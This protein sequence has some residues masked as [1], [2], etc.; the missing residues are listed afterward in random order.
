MSLVR[1][2]TATPQEMETVEGCLHVG[3]S[4]C[5]TGGPTEAVGIQS[6]RDLRQRTW[7]HQ[8]MP[9]AFICSSS[10]PSLAPFAFTF[11]CCKGEVTQA[12][13][14]PCLLTP[15]LAREFFP[16]QFTWEETSPPQESLKCLFQM[17]SNAF[18]LCPVLTVPPLRSRQ[19]TI[20]N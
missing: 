6:L 19:S 11:P 12:S 8:E 4:T 17:E 1:I 2:C 10:R 20:D 18:P 16:L 15:G 5:L 9:A 3:P 13:V 7:S 14:P